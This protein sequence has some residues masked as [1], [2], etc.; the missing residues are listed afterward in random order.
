[1][2]TAE[3]IRDKIYRLAEDFE[4]YFKEHK[5]AQAK[6]AYDTA[7]TMAVF[8]E[9]PE[10]DM[11]EL[12][13]NQNEDEDDYMEWGRFNMENVRYCYL[14]CIKHNATYEVQ[15]FHEPMAPK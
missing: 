6:Y 3:E 9:L 2:L 8:M 11:R 13:M 12:F 10:K 14:W 15:P 4:H 5:Y 1:M 7:S